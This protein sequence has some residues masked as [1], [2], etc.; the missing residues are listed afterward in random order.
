MVDMEQTL[1]IGN[2]NLK[3]LVLQDIVGKVHVIHDVFLAPVFPLLVHF[4]MH[5]LREC[6]RWQQGDGQDHGHRESKQNVFH[7]ALHCY[8][9]RVWFEMLA[10]VNRRFPILM[11]R[12]TLLWNAYRNNPAH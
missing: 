5:L 10:P 1:L 4:R 9:A 11:S 8:K 6:P 7:H 3:E 2:V 12:R